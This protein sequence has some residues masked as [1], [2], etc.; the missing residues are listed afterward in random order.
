MYTTYATSCLSSH[1]EP[2]TLAP[3]APRSSRAE[4][5][6]VKIFRCLSSLSEAPAASLHF[7]S[8]FLPRTLHPTVHRFLSICLSLDCAA[9]CDH[10]D[11]EC[12]LH[13]TFLS[14]NSAVC[15]PR[16][17]RPA[18][19]PILNQ[20]PWRRRRHALAGLSHAP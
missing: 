18:Y 13:N 8:T 2:A 19:P 3:K 20:R 9:R 10:P 7:V 15:I 12:D 6:P 5:R 4:P 16:T 17:P 11:F 1:F 14:S